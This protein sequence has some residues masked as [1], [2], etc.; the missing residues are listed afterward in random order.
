[1]PPHAY[2]GRGP[3][4]TVENRGGRSHARGCPQIRPPRVRRY[5]GHVHGQRSG[6]RRRNTHGVR[7]NERRVVRSSRTNEGGT[8]S[9]IQAGVDIPVSQVH[10]G[11]LFPNIRSPGSEGNIEELAASILQ[12][13][14][15]HP[16][17]VLAD[18]SDPNVYHLV[19]GHRRL[20][21]IKKI[22]ETDPQYF[23][24]ANGVAMLPVS[25]YTGSVTEAEFMNVQEN[26]HRQSVLVVDVC[27][28][29]HR[30]IAE[31]IPTEALAKLLEV[32]HDTITRY[33]NF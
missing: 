23:D 18:A 33:W 21:A 13:G 16:P 8:L 1:M 4:C 24:D 15:M 25:V 30:K 28:F 9:S 5:I 12:N 14:L 22:L 29:V 6:I 7:K 17:V 31:S 26:L 19:A 32:S 20:A 10:V 2:R 11:L 3:L 27:A